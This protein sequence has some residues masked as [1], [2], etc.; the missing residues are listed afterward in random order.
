MFEIKTYHQLR[1][2][3]RQGMPGT[4]GCIARTR[5]N[6]EAVFLTSQHVLF[7]AGAVQN[8]PVWWIR[9]SP[10]GRKKALLGNTLKGKIGRI[11]YEGYPCYIDCAIGSLLP[12]VWPNAQITYTGIADVVP[13]SRVTKTG[14]ATGTTRGHRR[15]Y[16]LPGA[17]SDQW[18]QFYHG[19]S[20]PGPP[21]KRPCVFRQRRFRRRSRRRARPHHRLIVGMQSGREK[22]LLH[23]SVLYSKKWISH[24][25]NNLRHDTTVLLTDWEK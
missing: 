23:P 17:G 3:N 25:S 14:H 20:N 2:T 1:I 11:M 6:G 10:A 5:S 16:T 21:V 18:R 15:R 19:K 8:D 7:A 9:E 22:G 12:G 4:L 13:G 24:Y